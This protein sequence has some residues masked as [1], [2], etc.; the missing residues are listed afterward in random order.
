MIGLDTNV[1]VRFLTHD[2]RRQTPIAIDIVTNR[3]SEDEPG[4]VSVV[5]LAEAAWVLNRVYRFDMRK[6]GEALRSMAQ[7]PCI[8]L[9]SQAETMAAIVAAERDGAD[10]ADVLIATLGISAG[11]DVTLTFDRKASRLPGFALAT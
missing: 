6:I 7:L 5:T 9:Q 8:R 3:L 4:F 2:D 11:C 1:I 10:L